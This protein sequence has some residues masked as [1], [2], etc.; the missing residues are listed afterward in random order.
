MFG[1]I[2][3]VKQ[4][5]VDTWEDWSSCLNSNKNEVLEI[6][7]EEALI[8]EGCFT[9]EIDGSTYALLFGYK[10]KHQVGSVNMNREINIKHS[11]IKKECFSEGSGKR[12][13]CQYIFNTLG[14]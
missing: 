2:Y 1:N 9:F 14:F 7:N 5:K 10:N 3:T 4:D 6:L 11:Q 13:N 8:L 12:A